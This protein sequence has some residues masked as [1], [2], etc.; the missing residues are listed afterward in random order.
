M[1][2]RYATYFFLVFLLGC[3]ENS[4]EKLDDGKQVVVVCTTGMV[5]DLAQ[6]IGG[7]RVRVMG[8]MGP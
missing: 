5:A 2:F 3:V 8:L 6:R 1:L 4:T 7:D